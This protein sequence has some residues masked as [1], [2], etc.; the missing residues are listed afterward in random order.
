MDSLDLKLPAQHSSARAANAIDSFLDRGF[1]G[2]VPV[3]NAVQCALLRRHLASYMPQEGNKELAV[4][5]PLVHE[6]ATHPVLLDLLWKILG[7]KVSLWGASVVPRMPGQ[8]H[9][10]HTDIESAAPEGGFVSIW[11]GFHNTSRDS[12]LHL[13]P[14]SHLYGSSVQEQ[15][16]MK[17]LGRG[18][19]EILD[20]AKQFDLQAYVEQPDVSDGDAIIFDGRIWHGSHNKRESG[21]RVA[22]LLQ[23][24][25]S[26]VPV[27]QPDMSQLDWPFR[28]LESRPPVIPVIG[29]AVESANRIAAPPEL[30]P[31]LPV[32][33]HQ[34]SLPL[35]L[36]DQKTTWQPF[37][38]GRGLTPNLRH[39]SFHASVLA[40][41]YAPHR[42]HAHL[43]EEILI[44][45][46]GEAELVIARGPRDP[47]PRIEHMTA[48]SFIYYP[49][50][51]FHT[52]R[53]RSQHPVS[54]LMFRW[55][56]GPWHA[57]SML[58]TRGWRPSPAGRPAPPGIF[59]PKTLFEGGTLFLKKLHF[60][61]TDLG[62]GATY[63]THAD[64][65][66]I[67]IVVFDGEIETMGRQFHR[68]GVV[69]IP[70]GELH[71][72]RNPGGINARYL[73]IEFH[74]RKTLGPG[75]LGPTLQQPSIGSPFIHTAQ[76][77]P[78]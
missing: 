63:E 17:G 56:D 28:F 53:N 58:K 10:W 67:A 69:Y 38:I 32:T 72:M 11:I 52:I 1:L 51:Q 29:D 70:G 16:A 12:G 30:G 49:A 34:F 15:R 33:T 42:P 4:S 76:A 64:D 60:H 48:G 36:P 66:D 21:M 47:S 37:R 19:G 26:G 27:Y 57:P 62:P 44:V 6:I 24:A 78:S 77:Q 3:L 14:G 46:D 43:D 23:Y 9:P 40:P 68:G 20:L 41:G 18:E 61:L 71:D 13:I 31:P 65:H 39:M 50:Y 25:A 75:I 22:L 55:M 8:V 59:A 5:D 7:N 45:L 74:G 35:K 54:Y 2:P 73:V